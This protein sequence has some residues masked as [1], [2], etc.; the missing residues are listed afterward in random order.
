MRTVLLL[1]L[2]GSAAAAQEAVDN[3]FKVWDAN[4]DGVLTPDEIPDP[5]IFAK[6]D[7]DQNGKITR[8]EVAAF[9]KVKPERKEAPRPRPKAGGEKKSEAAPMREPRS[10]KE[11]VADLF[12]RL[13]RNRDGKLQRV[14]LTG[15]TDEGFARHDRSRNGEWSE[16]EAMR[17]VREQVERAKRN[18]RP[19]NFFQ[20]FDLDR[21][22]RV[23]RREYDG[24]AAFFR[25][26]DH[27]KDRVV[28]EEELD[29]G[30]DAGRMQ[31]GDRAFMAD[32]PT[33]MPRQGLLD[34]YD[35]DGDGKITLEELGN[36]ESVLKRL[37]RNRDGVLSGSEVR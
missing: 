15:V 27:D 19:E 6:V 11:R 14:E 20:L 7:A 32:G 34:R 12:R 4:Q 21:D 13:D 9:F 10:V 37:D 30:P 26:Y 35:A 33:R 29:A 36:A 22:R 16:R 18:P 2:L 17:Y 8:A 31:R 5:A 1:A 28:T 24:P 23:T 25:R 3:V